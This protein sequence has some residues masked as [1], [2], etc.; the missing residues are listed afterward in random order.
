MGFLLIGYCLL[1]TLMA[2]WLPGWKII[3]FFYDDS[4]FYIKTA[5]YLAQGYGP[6][7]D[8]L[9]Q[10]N[11][12]HPLW[13][14][15][16]AIM[17]RIHPFHGVN[18]LRPL[19]I[20][21]ALLVGGAG[22]LMTASLK[23]VS[24]G[25]RARLL[26]L[27]FFLGVVGFSDYGLETPLLLLCSWGLIYCVSRLLRREEHTPSSGLLI[28]TGVCSALTCLARTDASLLVF[29]LTVPVISELTRTGRER[30]RALLPLM[31]ILAPA[32]LA[33]F[34]FAL[35]NRV[36]FGHA[37]TISS[38]LKVGWPG[39]LA[40]GVLRAMPG[41][42]KI[43][44]LFPI[45]VALPGTA[46]LVRRWKG[47][48]L[49]TKQ[50]AGEF[51]LLLSLSAYLLIHATILLLLANGLGAWY[52]TLDWTIAIA[53]ALAILARS[54]PDRLPLGPQILHRLYGGL[55]VFL[56]TGL[57]LYAA[58]HLRQAG[59][60]TTEALAVSAWLRANTDKNAVIYQVDW[61]GT[62]GYFSARHV[63]DGDGL[64]NN[65]E[66]QNYLKRKQF[67]EYLRDK[68]VT[69]LVLH[70]KTLPPNA[71]WID[72]YLPLWPQHTA[73]LLGAV[74][75]DRLVFSRSEFFICRASDFRIGYVPT[76]LTKRTPEA[77][78]ARVPR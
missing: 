29:C 34:A 11:G 32:L 5:Q 27:L 46:W 3:P 41:S 40:G 13:L 4:F 49:E 12:W 58:S 2:L 65:W 28:G 42:A 39:L 10:T 9:N 77:V 37:A 7:F 75:R 18:G 43:R 26:A 57:G 53:V 67:G 60:T 73:L 63:I 66:Y 47:R 62:V 30:R 24:L 17:A 61:S 78:R 15:I 48:C 25:A 36:Y 54:V 50:V 14:L 22:V 72:E 64:V 20:L 69:Y 21:H 56:L 70:R 1:V 68:R 44:L 71:L 35:Y 31:V 55:L 45:I 23:R 19:L 38:A 74:S 76:V 6:T 8:G 59:P 16:L 51:V 52:F 33:L